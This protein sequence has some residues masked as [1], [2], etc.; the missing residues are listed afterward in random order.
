MSKRTFI[1]VGWPV[2]WVLLILLGSAQIHSADEEHKG[3]LQ[4]IDAY[5][6][7]L[8]ASLDKVTPSHIHED[9]YHRLEWCHFEWDFACSPIA[10]YQWDERPISRENPPLQWP[11]PL[12]S[13]RA[14]P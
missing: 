11:K 4:K 7:E 12:N 9:F 14:R 10:E 1:L 2:L 8:N 13:S 6:N 3:F 5:V